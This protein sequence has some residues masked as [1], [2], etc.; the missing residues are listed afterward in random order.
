MPDPLTPE[1]ELEQLKQNEAAIA[2]RI[3]ELRTLKVPT[4]AAAVVQDVQ[5]VETA[6]GTTVR[7]V[8]ASAKSAWM[9]AETNVIRVVT[10]AFTYLAATGTVHTKSSWAGTLAGAGAFVVN[11]VTNYLKNHKLPG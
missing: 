7:T 3:E 8:T 6:V 11:E 10:A 1:Q 5:T 2:A 4:T 9:V